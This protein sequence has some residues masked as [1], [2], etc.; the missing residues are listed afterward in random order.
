[1]DSKIIESESVTKK[2]VQP[3]LEQKLA[4]KPKNPPRFSNDRIVN[5]LAAAIIGYFEFYVSSYQ[6]TQ[7]HGGEHA[8]TQQLYQSVKS[9]L[10]SNLSDEDMVPIIKEELPRASNRGLEFPATILTILTISEDTHFA[11]AL[12]LPRTKDALGSLV[13]EYERINGF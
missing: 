7:E 6:T 13:E 1:M 3:N 12:N 9:Y 8:P 11:Q 10:G 5:G 2:H 4:K